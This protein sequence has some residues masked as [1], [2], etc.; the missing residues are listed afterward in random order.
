MPAIR[1]YCAASDAA[2][3]FALWQGAFAR[4]W[5]LTAPMFAHVI[6]GPAT[7]PGG[8]HFVALEQG[9]TVGFVATGING[10]DPGSGY[11]PA[12]FVDPDMQRRGIGT[13][14]HKA[15]SDHLR[16]SGVRHVQLGGGLVRFWPGV[17]GTLATALAFF[18]A[19]GWAYAET[20]YDLLRDLRTYV[21][22]APIA[23]RMA[24]APFQLA[25]AQ[26]QDWP[27]L[28]AF[29]ARE[30]PFWADA[31][32]DAAH[33]GDYADALIARDAHGRLVGALLMVTP[34]SHPER[35]DAPWTALL[36]DRLGGL[37]AVGV[38]AD[39]RGRGI[40][41]A[42]VA[43]GSEILRERGAAYGFIGWTGLV[44]FYGRLGYAIWRDYR[45]SRRDVSY[46]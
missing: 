20:T 6:Q 3:V 4:T 18:Q 23:T 5:P 7:R 32:R 29:Q 14:L 26:E 39:R 2:A 10:A 43:R 16:H 12:L 15:A 40:G 38:A 34:Q 28:L 24:Q 31:Y 37:G 13:A 33:F 30:F 25:P 21:T 1:P 8:T 27:E 9:R 45:V 46:D 42:L 17:P 22:P 44:A 19:R 36:G 35:T 11:I 41:L